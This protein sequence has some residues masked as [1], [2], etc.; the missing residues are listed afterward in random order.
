[1]KSSW[2]TTAAF[3]SPSNAY[4]YLDGDVDI[5]AVLSIL[6]SEYLR[7]AEPGERLALPPLQ[8]PV[9]AQPQRVEFELPGRGG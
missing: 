4:V 1:M 9:K 2:T 5:D 7:D 6:D 3:H 8:K